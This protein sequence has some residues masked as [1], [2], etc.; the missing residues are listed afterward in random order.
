MSNTEVP[1]ISWMGKTKRVAFSDMDGRT[2]VDN[3]G[4]ISLTSA[5]M[6]EGYTYALPH[7][8][9]IYNPED[10]R[11]RVTT[12]EII[13]PDSGDSVILPCAY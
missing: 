8:E 4:G 12:R 9:L 7:R 10:S 2:V 5:E 3:C 6:E 11:G 1:A 13:D